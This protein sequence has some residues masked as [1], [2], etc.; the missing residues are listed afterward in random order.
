MSH[1]ND[2]IATMI[3]IIN[4]VVILRRAKALRGIVC[5]CETAV[6]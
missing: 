5:S 2:A 6:K 4:H 1:G 3:S